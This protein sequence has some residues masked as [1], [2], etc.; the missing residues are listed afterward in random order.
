MRLEARARSVAGMSNKQDPPN[1]SEAVSV[2]GGD[3]TPS[4][5]TQGIYVG[6]TGN[7]V[8][9]HRDDSSDRTYTAIPAGTYIRGD[10]TAIR[11]TGTTVTNSVIQGVS[12]KVN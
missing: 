6:G 5:R 9:R 3:Q 1:R 11:Q 4:F 8:V 7:L 10:F 12:Q 2:G